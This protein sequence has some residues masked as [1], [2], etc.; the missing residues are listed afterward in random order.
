MSSFSCARSDGVIDSTT[1]RFVEDVA[2]VI[3]FKK[4]FFPLALIGPISATLS[5]APLDL[6]HA[7]IVLL[8]PQAKV[9][10]KAAAML[11]DE[12]DKRTRIG[13]EIAS[14]LPEGNEPG[15]LI[16]TAEE[17]ARESFQPVAGCQLPAVPD[18]C[19]VWV[20]TTRGGRLSVPLVTICAGP[21]S[22]WAASCA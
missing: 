8:N 15:I 22:L 2:W 6:S 17:L 21:C 13:L 4:T 12:V 19:A 11:R 7:K 5:A 1:G 20:D 16:G 9:E 3:M 18:A 10:V 14:K